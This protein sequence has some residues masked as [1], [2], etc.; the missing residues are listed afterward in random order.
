MYSLPP[1]VSRVRNG[2]LSSKFLVESST[3][4]LINIVKAS[5]M[6][7]I[8]S[9]LYENKLVVQIPTDLTITTRDRNVYTRAITV[10]QG[11]D[12]IL[13]L[14][15]QNQ[16][17]KPRPLTGYTL[18]FQIIDDFVLANSNVLFQTT[19]VEANAAAGTARVL[20]DQANV[21]LLERDMYKYSVSASYTDPDFGNVTIPTYVDDNWGAAGQMLVRTSSFPD[22]PANNVNN[23][24]PPSVAF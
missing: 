10:Y 5:V 9:Y 4:I 6:N 7:T 21:A 3:R 14:Q 2:Y 1:Y 18:V 11:V 19:A 8:Q 12:N 15:V 13:T 20:I 23:P 22:S 16:D 24:P 17:Q